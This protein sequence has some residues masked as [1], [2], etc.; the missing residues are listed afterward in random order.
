MNLNKLTIKAQEAIA[1]AQMIAV[2]NHQQQITH[3]T[4]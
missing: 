2:K 3:C 1:N 4:F